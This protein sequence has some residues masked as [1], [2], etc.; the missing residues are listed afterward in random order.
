MNTRRIVCKNTLRINGKTDVLSLWTEYCFDMI[1]CETIAEKLE[2]EAEQA[3]WT[4]CCRAMEQAEGNYYDG[5]DPEAQED[6]KYPTYAEMMGLDEDH[7]IRTEN[8]LYYRT[9]TQFIQAQM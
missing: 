2:D 3:E 9:D 6:L 1:W 5:Y 8:A 7:M 4:A